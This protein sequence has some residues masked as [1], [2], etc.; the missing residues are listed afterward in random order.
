MPLVTARF[1]AL[2]VDQLEQEGLPLERWIEGLPV[3]PE[4]VLEPQ[5]PLEWHD[6]IELLE[7]AATHCGGLDEIEAFMC[8]M[9]SGLPKGLHSMLG[10]V[11]SLERVYETVAR[12][13]TD[14]VS[15]PIRV[16]ARVRPGHATLALSIDEGARTS[17]VVWY[18][19]RGFVRRIPHQLGMQEPQVVSSFDERSARFEVT[20]SRQS[21]F[22]RMRRRFRMLAAS[23]QVLQ[24]FQEQQRDLQL[25]LRELEHQTRRLQEA[26]QQNRTLVDDLEHIVAE[27]TGELEA[28]SEE[29][30]GLQA[31]LIQAERL[32]AAQELAGSVAHAI[33]NPLTALIGQIQMMV[34]SHDPPDP[35]MQRL[36]QVARRIRDVV[37]RT[38]QLFRQG[39]L[40]LR[41]EDPKRLLDDVAAL[42]RPLA[43]EARV[44][45]ETKCEPGLPGLEVDGPLL[46]AALVSLGENAIEASPVGGIVELELVAVPSLKVV[47]FRIRDS[48]PGMGAKLR[49]KALEPFFTTKPGGTGLGLAIAHGVV[50][51]HHGRLRLLR[52]PGGGTLATVELPL[53]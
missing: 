16:Q 30:R 27:R 47:E 25:T 44:Q 39:E 14:Q 41:R 49:E 33:N 53:A 22:A 19:I 32:G 13:L 36:D 21:L 29:L 1:L 4:Q 52:R 6:F 26:Q 8:R 48:G 20:F 17:P 50:A 40:D 42:L 51:G 31:Q 37:T 23:G 10:M 7:R 2:M 28:Q 12:F 43:D 11:V 15:P 34:E 38:L 46:R 18:G 3:R 45:V 9:E 5:T 24:E 35:R